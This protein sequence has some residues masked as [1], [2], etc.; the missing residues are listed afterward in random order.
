MGSEMCIRDRY[1][2]RT[3]LPAP[4]VIPVAKTG[5]DTTNKSGSIRGPDQGKKKSFL[6]LGRAEMKKKAKQQKKKV[7][8]K[9]KAEG[10]LI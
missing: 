7:S 8:R 4:S 6:S 3:S 5:V 2:I 9:R 10:R 1:I